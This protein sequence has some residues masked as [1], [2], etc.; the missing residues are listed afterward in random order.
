[1]QK[2]RD[3]GSSGLVTIPKRYLDKDDVLEDGGIP[4]EIAVDVERLDRRT[5]AVRI[6][7]DGD[8]PEL[9]EAQFVERI[10]G[11]RLVSEGLVSGAAD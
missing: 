1:M 9:R 7:E 3:D 4:E 6:A 2:L 8:F 5:Y 10:L 11:E